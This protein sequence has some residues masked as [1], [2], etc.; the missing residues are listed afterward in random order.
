M[1]KQVNNNFKDMPKSCIQGD[2]FYSPARTENIQFEKD[3][4]HFFYSSKK[5]QLYFLIG[6]III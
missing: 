5:I 3:F 6:F 1:L 2:G 4:C